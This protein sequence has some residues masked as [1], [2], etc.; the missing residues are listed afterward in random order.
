MVVAAFD[1]AALDRRDIILF[2]RVDLGHAAE[3]VVFVVMVV[4]GAGQVVGQALAHLVVADEIFLTFGNRAQRGFFFGMRG[5]FGQQ[6]FAILLGDLV[7]VRVDFAEGEEP[8]TVS[9][10]VDERCLQRRF[11]PGYLGEIDVALDLL[12]FSRFK[13]ELFNPIALEHRHPGFFRVA[14]ID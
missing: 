12:V 3:V 9:A 7:I 4:I 2:G 5:L 1:V 8:M 13:V 11:D 10:E 6:L 14:R